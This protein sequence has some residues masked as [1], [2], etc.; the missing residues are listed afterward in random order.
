MRKLIYAGFL[1]ALGAFLT[2]GNAG[3][4]SNQLV[5]VMKNQMRDA[6]VLR[7]AVSLGCGEIVD[8]GELERLEDAAREIITTQDPAITAQADPLKTYDLMVAQL[9]EQTFTLTSYRYDKDGCLGVNNII[10]MYD[11]KMSPFGP[12]L[13]IY[14]PNEEAGFAM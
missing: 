2:Y 14:E 5:H 10:I 8:K 13:R 4:Q 11:N 12:A 3:A 1:G 7:A 6:A 9:Q